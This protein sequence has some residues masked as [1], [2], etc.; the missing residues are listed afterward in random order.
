MRCPAEW[1]AP[2]DLDAR[3]SKGMGSSVVQKIK[4]EAKKVVHTLTEKKNNEVVE[5]ARMEQEHAAKEQAE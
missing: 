3:T 4:E 2:S 1:R 5:K